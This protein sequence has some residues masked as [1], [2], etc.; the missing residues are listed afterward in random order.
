MKSRVRL[1]TFSTIITIVVIAF[2]L[3][4]IYFSIGTYKFIP[5]CVITVVLL[6]FSLWFSPLSISLDANKININSS[7]HIK[8]IPYDTIAT[9][10]RFQPTMGAKRKLGSGGFM[11]YW[12][13]FAEGDVG[14]Y[15]AFYGKSSDCFLI[16]LKDG[17]KYVLG[18]NDPDKMVNEIKRHLC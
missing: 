14:N 6:G 15:T 9:V 16:T 4:A 11:G 7:L 10:E 2:L 17:G 12:G 13:M 3:L 5:A 1:S 18:C 8:S